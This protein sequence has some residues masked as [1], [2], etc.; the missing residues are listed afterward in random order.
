MKTLSEY[1]KL[2]D[3]N[4][5]NPGVLSVLETEIAADYGYLSEVLINIKKVK[6][7][8]WVKI[9]IGKMNKNEKG[10]WE[11]KPRSDELTKQLWRKDYKEGKMEMEIQ[12]TMKALEKYMTSIQSYL[13]IRN[14]EAKNQY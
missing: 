7:D 14:R 2:I 11:G 8:I 12:Y 10:E 6:P 3:E 13:Y 4:K 1:S 5:S 9:K